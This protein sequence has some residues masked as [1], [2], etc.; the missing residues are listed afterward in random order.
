MLQESYPPPFYQAS[1]PS[2]FLEESHICSPFL[3]PVLSMVY[4]LSLGKTTDERAELCGI[5]LSTLTLYFTVCFKCRAPGSSCPQEWGV[6]QPPLLI[7]T[8]VTGRRKG[9]QVG[10]QLILTLCFSTFSSPQP[11]V[12]TH[13]Q[14]SLQ[15]PQWLM[16]PK[17]CRDFLS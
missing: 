3:L 6:K 14:H 13:Q 17:P 15:E 12:P 4:E 5:I 9:S 10:V 7:A 16:R 8:G 11:N 1:L 2:A